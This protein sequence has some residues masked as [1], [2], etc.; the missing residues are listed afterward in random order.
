MSETP[1]QT[2][3]EETTTAAADEI[4][5]TVGLRDV[6]YA[7]LTTDEAGEDPAYGEVNPLVGA[8]DFDLSD[9]SGDEDAQYYDDHEGDVLYPDPEMTGTLEMADILPERL[10][11]LLGATVDENGVLVRTADD[12]PPYFAMGFKSEKSNG[13]DRYVWLYK[14]R[15]KLGNQKFTTKQG[16]TIT[17]QTT[18]LTITFIKRT[19]D[20]LWQT[21][22][23]TDND[24]FA[25]A[26]ATFFST[27]YE[28]DYG[29]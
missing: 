2:T 24:D 3:S 8:I 6:V 25:S 15:A 10:A 14:G 7:L 20:G 16:K 22:A 5:S 1:T 27:V 23:D 26:A 28:P 21:F 29:T 19:C 4:Y 9:N 13:E 11:V 12:K 18:K 17:R